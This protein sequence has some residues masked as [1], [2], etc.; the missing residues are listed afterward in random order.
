MKPKPPPEPID[1]GIRA[2]TS[3][4]DDPILNFDSS[5]NQQKLQFAI[6]KVKQEKAVIKLCFLDKCRGRPVNSKLF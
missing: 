4:A 2:A 3:I 1:L 6:N 5:I